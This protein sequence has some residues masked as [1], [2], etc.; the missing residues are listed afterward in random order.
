MQFGSH[1]SA[2]FLQIYTFRS[3]PIFTLHSSLNIIFL[4]YSFTVL[5][6][7]LLHHT[8]LFFLFSCRILIFFFTTLLKYPS[9]VKALFTVLSDTGTGPFSLKMLVISFKLLRRFSR[10]RR[11]IFRLSW[12][13]STLGR[14]LRGLFS[15]D[16]TNRKQL[17]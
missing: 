1:S 17:T 3:V 16:V 5:D 9:C 2:T 15:N 14:P 10:T 7:S 13:V 11:N 6:L 4:Q 8:S 12:S